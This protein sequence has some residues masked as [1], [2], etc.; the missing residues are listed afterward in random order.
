MEDARK[1]MMDMIG[2]LHLTH[3]QHNPA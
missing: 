1:I 2:R 3:F